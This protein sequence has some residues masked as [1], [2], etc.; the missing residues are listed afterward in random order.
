MGKKG[1]GGST[2]ML[3]P[4]NYAAPTSQIGGRE[5]SPEEIRLLST[6]AAALNQGMEIAEEQEARSRQLHDIWK[7]TY[8]PVETGMI[9]GDASEANGYIDSAKM[10]YALNDANY[11]TC[12][13]CH[14]SGSRGGGSCRTCGGAGKV[15]AGQTGK[16]IDS[17]GDIKPQAAAAQASAK[18]G[19][20]GNAS[21][22]SPTGSRSKGGIANP[23]DPRTQQPAQM[24]PSQLTG[25]M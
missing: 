12:P 15:P 4:I 2:T 18:G 14:G 24:L 21:P 19:V 8:L 9:S 23:M 3:Q 5:Q 13:G 16:L 25:G 1:G 17:N 10:N 20:S 7:A 6:Q 22:F 11:K